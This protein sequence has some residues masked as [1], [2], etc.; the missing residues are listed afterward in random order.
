MLFIKTIFQE[1]L[2]T[3]KK[4]IITILTILYEGLARPD[5]GH[6]YTLG[7]RRT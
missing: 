3:N 6:R 5:Q 4:A 7:E 2:C 1:V